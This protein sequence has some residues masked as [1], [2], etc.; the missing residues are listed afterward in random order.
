MAESVMRYPVGV[1]QLE[2]GL[3]VFVPGVDNKTQIVESYDEAQIKA[4]ELLDI[5][6]GELADL[7]QLPPEPL[8]LD[9]LISNNTKN[10]VWLLV[11]INIE[12]YMGRSSKVNVTLPNLLRKQIDD[13]VTNNFK[14]KDRSDFLQTA[15]INELSGAKLIPHYDGL[16]ITQGDIQ[17]YINNK[18]DFKFRV[19]LN[20]G[21]KT[22]SVVIEH[23]WLSINLPYKYLPQIEEFA[24][25]T[26]EE[27]VAQ[28]R[29]KE[30]EREREEKEKMEG[31]EENS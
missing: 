17:V 7:G 15:A 28:W 5:Y 9:L 10:I 14:Y 12:P 16:I 22:K 23:F 31:R 4:L 20:L 21:L 24:G 8:S 26:Y 1:R 27:L 30:E 25:I 2:R 19:S 6:L 13:T 11:E 18:N 3:E 29:K